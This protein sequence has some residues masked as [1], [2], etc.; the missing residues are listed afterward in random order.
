M[1]TI[2]EVNLG[3]TTAS[4]EKEYKWK[5]DD[6]NLTL[7]EAVNKKVLDK[8][9]S[10]AFLPQSIRTFIISYQN[11]SKSNLD[12]SQAVIKEKIKKSANQTMSQITKKSPDDNKDK[13]PEVPLSLEGT[14]GS[15][16]L[17]QT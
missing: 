6:D 14:S 11:E 8:G 17:I 15:I 13:D 1:I 9:E 7:A 3:G 5:G 16:E 10:R 2:E 12:L 4:K